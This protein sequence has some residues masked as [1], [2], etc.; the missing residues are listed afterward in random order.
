MTAFERRSRWKCCGTTAFRYV[1]VIALA[2]ARR[3]RVG[4]AINPRRGLRVIVHLMGHP[5]RDTPP[6]GSGKTGGGVSAGI[7]IYDTATLSNSKSPP[8]ALR[9]NIALIIYVLDLYNLSET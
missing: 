2:V 4:G 8:A 3:A 5:L 1:L 6:G 9:L 7:D